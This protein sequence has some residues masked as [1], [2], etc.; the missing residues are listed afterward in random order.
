MVIGFLEPLVMRFKGEN[1]VDT[2]KLNE[3]DYNIQLT[4]QA[5]ESVFL[6]T[7]VPDLKG[8]FTVNIWNENTYSFLITSLLNLIREYNGL[9]DILTV[10]HLNPFS[11]I[12]LKH[13]SFGDNGSDLNELISQYKKTLD[14]LN[15]GLEKVK[16]I[17]KLNG[18]M[19][20]SQ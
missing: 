13:L 20:D 17:L 19:E 12:N 1:M 3:I 15:N 18:L 2:N 9:L 10:N 6:T 4:Y 14:K 7:E 16:V 5:I 8:P 11:N